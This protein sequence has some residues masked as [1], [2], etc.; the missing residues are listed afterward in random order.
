MS[1]PRVLPPDHDV[2]RVVPEGVAAPASIPADVFAAAVAS[3]VA[4]QRLDMQGLARKLCVGR[5][6]LYRR[7]GN[8][9]RLLAEVIWWRSRHAVADAL[10][11]TA[12]LTGVPRLVAIIGAVLTASRRDS[13]LRA[14]LEADPE[15]ALQILT[16]ADS[17]VQNGMMAVLETLIEVETERGTL[18]VGLDKSLLAYAILRIAEGFLYADVIAD[19]T[20]DVTTALT[21]IEALLRGLDSST[22]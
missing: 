14:F 6:T 7:A 11:N 22:P 8:R 1:V 18:R 21:V 5:A 16:G 9:E 17:R 19:R 13:A 12:G 15:T 10:H 2:E 3:Y 4:G 20:P